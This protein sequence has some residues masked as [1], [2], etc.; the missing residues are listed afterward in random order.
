[1]K[2]NIKDQE[3]EIRW[4]SRALMN[5][6]NLTQKSFTDVKNYNDVMILFYSFILG[7]TK[8]TLQLSWNEF[9]DW[10][11]EDYE[12]SLSEHRQSV[13][14]EFSSWYTSEIE[15]QSSLSADMAVEVNNEKKN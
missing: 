14:I 15:R 8:N 3:I 1:M 12:K 4:T 6:E 11:D 2:I 13:E 7:S 5:Y 10:I 9:C